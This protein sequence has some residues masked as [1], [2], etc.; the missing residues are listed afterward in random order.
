MS[1]MLVHGGTI[2]SMDPDTGDLTGD[3][4]IRDGVIKAIAPDMECP[5]DCELVDAT[6]MIVMPGFV[7]A[8]AHL[9]Q[10]GLRGIAGDW[11]IAEYLRAM[12]AGLAT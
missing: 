12:H 1:G 10:T 7:N 5:A 6:G 8:H 4:L 2:V 11:A 9:W 3:I